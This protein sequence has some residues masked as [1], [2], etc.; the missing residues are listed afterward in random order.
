MADVGENELAAR[1]A[2]FHVGSRVGRRVDDIALAALTIHE[3]VRR[4]PNPDEREHHNE[5][6]RNILRREFGELRHAV[7]AA[8]KACGLDPEFPVG[9]RLHRLLEMGPG[10]DPEDMFHELQPL[11][12][13]LHADEENAVRDAPVRYDPPLL[14]NVRRAAGSPDQEKK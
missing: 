8:K 10:A 13:D 14:R 6:Q 4:H 3:S 11:T 9:E 1:L 12:A 5:V 2:C 7:D